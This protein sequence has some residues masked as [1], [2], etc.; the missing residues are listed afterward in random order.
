MSPRL[1]GLFDNGKQQWTGLNTVHLHKTHIFLGGLP[2]PWTPCK[3]AFSPARKHQKCW[4]LYTSLLC[5]VMVCSVVSCSAM[6]LYAMLCYVTHAAHIMHVMHVMYVV[7]VMAKK[8]LG[9]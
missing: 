3:R 9:V 7:H 8:Y 4:Q 2:P 1:T 6:L 5:C